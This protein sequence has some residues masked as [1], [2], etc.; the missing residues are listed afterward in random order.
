L[1]R[2][3]LNTPA[4][5]IATKPQLDDVPEL[6]HLSFRDG[7]AL[8]MVLANARAHDLQ[9]WENPTPMLAGQV[10]PPGVFLS[11]EEVLLRQV[12]AFTLD[13]YVFG[14]TVS[15]DYLITPSRKRG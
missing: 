7:N 1:R 14:S 15:V 9:F 2:H 5:D 6:E 4:N 3:L 8:N 12:T 13:V 10:R 11:A